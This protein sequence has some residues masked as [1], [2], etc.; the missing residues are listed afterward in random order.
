MQIGHA[1]HEAHTKGYEAEGV[2]CSQTQTGD[3]TG[4]LAFPL[5]AGVYAAVAD[6]LHVCS[7][8]H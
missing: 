5:P 1:Y 2:T 4:P 7:S 8:P 3:D 6:F